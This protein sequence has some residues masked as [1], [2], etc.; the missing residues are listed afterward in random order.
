MDLPALSIALPDWVHHFPIARRY[1]D[2]ESRMEVAI[3]LA[4][5]NVL[6]GG[7]PFGAA[8]FDTA[9]GELLSVGVNMVVSNNNS[10]L[11][12]EVVAV[13]IAQARVGNYTLRSDNASRDLVTSCEPC[14][15]CVGAVFWSGVR[16]LVCGASR[17][18]ALA[19]GFDEGPVFP[20]SYEYLEHRGLGV[21]RGVLRAEAAEVLR[22]YAN[23]DGILYN[24]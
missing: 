15:M 13:M 24:G 6:H 9:S 17:A 22:L 10:V 14:A 21:T 16:R 18:D 2:D 20:E 4:R 5:E 11:H 8:I 1:P 19:T 23:S 12:A 7:G 3:A